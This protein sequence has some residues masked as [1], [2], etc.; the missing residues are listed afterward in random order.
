MCE[1]KFQAF[2]KDSSTKEYLESVN[3]FKDKWI[4]YTQ[5]EDNPSVYWKEFVSL[6]EF[7]DVN[8]FIFRMYTGWK[9]K[10]NK[11]IF[12][13]DIIKYEYQED[14]CWGKAGVYTGHIRFDKG[15]F[16]IVHHGDRI[17]RY[18]DGSWYEPSKYSDIKSFMSWA[19]NIEIIGNVYEN[20]DLMD[21]L[22]IEYE[23]ENR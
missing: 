17:I 13:G 4:R 22:R 11:E 8:V 3:V 21:R 10:N 16:E 12:Q 6:S 7:D 23:Y 1:I 2:V 15:V 5:D 9:D 20:L 18:P 14:S 19:R